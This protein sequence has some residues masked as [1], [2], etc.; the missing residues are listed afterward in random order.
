MLSLQSIKELKNVT[1][2]AGSGEPSAT[3]TPAAV[4]E[5]VEPAEPTQTGLVVAAPTTGPAPATAVTSTQPSAE[6]HQDSSGSGGVNTAR[7]EDG[8]LVQGEKAAA[9]EQEREPQEAAPPLVA[10]PQIASTEPK[11]RG[12]LLLDL[13]RSFRGGMLRVGS[14]LRGTMF[15]SLRYLVSAFVCIPTLYWRYPD[16]FYHLIY[17]RCC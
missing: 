7:V 17:H 14:N 5:A 15:R 1:S 3:A 9:G 11:T 8:E 12:E 4:A 16:E 2:L 6:T 10:P 13:I